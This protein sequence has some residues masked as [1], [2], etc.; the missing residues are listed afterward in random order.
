MIIIEKTII[1]DELIGKQFACALD[2]CKGACCVSGDSG[3]PLELDETEVLEQ[4]FDQVKPFMSKEGINSIEKFGKWIIDSE[5][6]L[7]TPLVDGVK[8]CAYVFLDKGIAKCAIE[9]AYYEGK[10]AFKKP[11]SCHLYPVRIKKYENYEA[12]NYDRWDICSP[13]CENGREL[14]I[15]IYKFV[16]EALIRKYGIDWYQQLEGAAVFEENR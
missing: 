12:V 8:E 14:G 10:I 4:V 7:V 9:R 15:P 13:A 3:A 16:K 1:S 2:K 11:V 6:D 5:G